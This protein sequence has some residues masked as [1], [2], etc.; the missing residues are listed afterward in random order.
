ML[1][2]E[3]SISIYGTNKDLMNVVLAKSETSKNPFE[4]NATD[5]FTVIDPVNVGKVNRY[6]FIEF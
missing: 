3:V 6:Y 5:V 1:L 4:N 2:A